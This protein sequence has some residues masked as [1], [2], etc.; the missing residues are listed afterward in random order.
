[1]SLLQALLDSYSWD[2]ASLTN[3]YKTA[4]RCTYGWLHTSTNAL[5]TA[6][7]CEFGAADDALMPTDAHKVFRD[8][9]QKQHAELTILRKRMAGVLQ[10]MGH[11]DSNV[12]DDCAARGSDWLD[13]L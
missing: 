3:A 6:K 7:L 13:C 9:I 1:V 10:A 5:I 2:A 11:E 12:V 8:T 4:T